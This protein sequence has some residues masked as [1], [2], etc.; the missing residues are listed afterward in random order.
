M[1]N[2]QLELPGEIVKKHNELVRGKLSVESVLSGRMLGAL[3]SQIKVTDTDFKEIYKLDAKMVMKNTSGKGYKD[4]KKAI[5]AL[6][7]STIEMEFR[8][9]DDDDY[10]AHRY[11]MYAAPIFTVVKIE[12]STLI[13]KFNIEVKK[14]LIQLGAF[15]TQYKFV[16]YMELSSI[17]SQRLFEFLVSWSSEPEITFSI[18]ELYTILKVPA[19]FKNKYTNFKERVLEKAHSEISKKTSF[20]YEWIPIKSG[21]TIVAIRFIFAKNRALPIA[22][23]KEKEI[24]QKHS[25]LSLKSFN[26]AI[27]CVKT[28]NGVCVKQDNKKVVC[29]ICSQFKMCDELLKKQKE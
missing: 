2:R 24:Q 1:I 4:A 16:D 27:S 12:K 23:E 13:A 7:K 21:R 18:D 20:S 8:Y 28:K 25:T 17:Y 9:P 15:F 3:I 29:S 11:F 22:K 6:A 5:S 10:S 19:S 14:Y 26:L